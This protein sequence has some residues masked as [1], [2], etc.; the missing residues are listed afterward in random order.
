MATPHLTRSRRRCGSSGDG[1]RSAAPPHPALV[2]CRLPPDSSTAC[3]PQPAPCCVA[4]TKRAQHLMPAPSVPRVHTDDFRCTSHSPLA[5]CTWWP[6]RAC[7]CTFGIRHSS[8]RAVRRTHKPKAHCCLHSPG[9]RV[10]PPALR[11]R[12]RTITSARCHSCHAQ[13]PFLPPWLYHHGNGGQPLHASV[14]AISLAFEP[15]VAAVQL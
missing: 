8:R 4:G 1:V 3:T 9:F 11:P 13:P 6:Q 10:P 5:C 12:A 2:A 15:A 7:L 14:Y